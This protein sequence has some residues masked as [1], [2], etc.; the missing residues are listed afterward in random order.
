[1]LLAFVRLLDK[2]KHKAINCKWAKTAYPSAVKQASLDHSYFD[3]ICLQIYPLLDYV[4][5]FG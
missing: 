3:S 5:K 1:M 4:E 2:V